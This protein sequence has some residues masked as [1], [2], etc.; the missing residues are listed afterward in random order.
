[1][2][3]GRERLGRRGVDAASRVQRMGRRRRGVR[4]I[5]VAVDGAVD[6]V[7]LR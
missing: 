2:G 3:V 4:D 7:A 5:V 6:W 1:M